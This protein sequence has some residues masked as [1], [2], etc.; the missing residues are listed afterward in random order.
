MTNYSRSEL[1]R[2]ARE[3]LLGNYTVLIL[4]L[5]TASAVPTMLLTPFSIGLTAEFNFAMVTYLLAAILVKVLCGLFPSAW[6]GCSFFWHRSSRF[7]IWICFGRFA[8]SQT[9]F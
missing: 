2:L 5:L 8:T 3:A 9:G 7:P 6:S 1:K 4:A